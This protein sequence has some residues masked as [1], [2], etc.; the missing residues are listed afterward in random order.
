MKNITLREIH[1]RILEIK[2]ILQEGLD[3]KHY[4][5]DFLNNHRLY[6]VLQYPENADLQDVT[7]KFTQWFLRVEMEGVNFYCELWNDDLFKPEQFKQIL[8][9]EYSNFIYECSKHIL[10]ALKDVNEEVKNRIK[11]YLE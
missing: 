9:D 5:E 4:Y 10:P 1:N 6:N 11:E 8:D 2:K 7:V 3:N